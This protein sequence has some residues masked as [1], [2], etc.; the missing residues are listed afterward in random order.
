MNNINTTTAATLI[1]AEGGI[2]TTNVNNRRHH[3]HSS[4]RNRRSLSHRNRHQQQQHNHTSPPTFQ[5]YTTTVGSSSSSDA[6]RPT[7]SSNATSQAMNNIRL[8]FSS[9]NGQK[10]TE[11]NLLAATCSIF[12]IA[13]LAV[14]LIEIRWFYLNGG[15]CNVNYLGAAHFFS[16][17]RLQY[18]LELSK[19]TKSEVRVYTFTLSNGLELRNCANREIMLIMRTCIAFV[20]LAVFSA[21]CGLMLDTFGSMRPGVRMLR[22]NAVFHIITVVFCLVVNGLCFWMSEKMVSIYLFL[23]Q[24]SNLIIKLS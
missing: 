15:G 22:R 5:I 16:P 23:F 12:C 17:G 2:T 4:R 24:F 19:V 18:Q 3:H 7:T 20:F 8:M 13:I 10:K 6:N 21:C 9:G 11:R 1:S 14:S